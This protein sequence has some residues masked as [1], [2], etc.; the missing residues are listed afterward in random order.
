PLAPPPAP[1]V[2]T[3][4]IGKTIALSDLANRMGV[5]AKEL[6]ATLVARGFY[7]LNAKTVLPRETARVIA[8]MFGWRVEDAPAELDESVPVKS[9][10]RSRIA[11]KRKVPKAA[12]KAAKTKT[13]RRRL[14]R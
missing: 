3:V 11:T 1:A 12:T 13:A 10:T 5:P 6:P 7:A 2:P 4:H 14:A 8:E 9:G